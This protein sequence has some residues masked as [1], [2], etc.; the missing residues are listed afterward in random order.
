I[1]NS[2]TPTHQLPNK[3]RLFSCFNYDPKTGKN[4]P[5]LGLLFI[6]LPAILTIFILFTSNYLG[7]SERIG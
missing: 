1:Y 2:F 6:A 3:N 5:G 7:K 4:T